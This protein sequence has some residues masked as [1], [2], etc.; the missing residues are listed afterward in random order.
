MITPQSFA[1]LKGLLQKVLFPIIV[2]LVASTAPAL[3]GNPTGPTTTT[4]TSSPATAAVSGATVTFTATV[5]LTSGGTAVNAGT[6]KL[7]DGTTSTQIGSTT[8]VN[9]SG[10]ATFTSSTL[11]IQTH[12]IQAQYTD[13]AGLHNSNS[14]NLSLNITEPTALALTSS[15]ASPGFGT[16]VT[17]TATVTNGAT[18]AAITSGL[19]TMKIFDNNGGATLYNGSVPATGIVTYS[20]TTLAIGTHPITAQYSDGTSW[21]PTANTNVV[22]SV[23]S[24]TT[25]SSSANPSTFG[26]S[27]TFTATVSSSGGTPT[28]TVRFEDGV[29]QPSPSPAPP[30]IATVALS[31]GTATFTTTALAGGT[32]PITAEFVP[33]VGGLAA[34]SSPTISQVVNTAPTTTTVATPAASVVGA[35]VAL[36][37]TVTSGVGTPGGSV[38]FIDSGQTIGTAS[39]ITGAATLNTTA[40]GAGSHTIT[41]QYSGSSNFT[42]SSALTG[43][44]NIGAATT[45]TT[46]SASPASAGLGGAVNFT[47]LVSASSG[48]PSG[49]VT[50]TD[51]TTGL[52]V[53]TA[54]LSGGQ[55]V[56]STSTLASGSHTIIATYGGTS[57]YGASVS[58]TGAAVSISAATTTLA[59]SALPSPA[60]ALGNSVLTAVILPSGGPTPTGT[61][62][63]TDNGNPVSG[64]PAAVNASGQASV[65]DSGLAVGT[66]SLAASYTGSGSAAGGSSTGTASLTVGQSTSTTVVTSSAN[67]QTTPSNSIT[68]TATVTGAG[69]PTGS[70]IF[71][72]GTLTLATVPLASGVATLSRTL[73]TAAHAI[74]ATYSGDANDTASQGLLT[75]N[76][77]AG[78]SSTV[79]TVSPS[80]AAPGQTVTLGA[81]VVGSS[82]TGTVTFY[83][84]A[85]PPLTIVGSA[86]VGAQIV[87]TT[88]STG[89]HSLSAVYSGDSNNTTSTSS[90]QTFTIAKVSSTTTLTSVTANPGIAGS[91]VS[92][93]YHIASAVST[94]TSPTGIVSFLDGSSNIGTATL[95]SNNNGNATLTTSSLASGSHTVTAAYQGDNQNNASTSLALPFSVTNGGTADF[96]LGTSISYGVTMG[97]GQS[98]TIPLS[99][100]GTN[101]FS[102]T[103]TITC[104]GLPQGA[105]CVSSPPTVAV[106]SSSPTS[107]SVLLSTTG[108]HSGSVAPTGHAIR[109]A[110]IPLFGLAALFAFMRRRRW[111][112][113]TVAGVFALCILSACG[114]GGGGSTLPGVGSNAGSGS[115]LGIGTGGSSGTGGSGSATPAPGATDPATDGQPPTITA[116]TGLPGIISTSLGPNGPVLPPT[117][118]PGAIVAGALTPGTSSAPAGQTPGGTSTV[119]IVATGSNGVAHPLN[120]TVV[121][122]P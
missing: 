57:N 52:T 63:F 96:T 80:S 56:A 22:I 104:V 27:V 62:T 76:V 46:V 105:T 98:T 13:P 111:R 85:S 86:Q 88:L 67:P 17:I 118:A 20:T 33:Q 87:V 41:A 93:S 74:S 8:A 68:F 110:A 106:N 107:V 54:S 69:T 16:N 120:I 42:N 89:T 119:A 61:V 48:S 49:T 103:V 101:G 112:V 109:R 59:L 94:G 24:T 82:P 65:T 10:V 32:H 18:G 44:F 38:A 34:S 121:I 21:A 95:A 7:M 4:L 84:G 31:S 11:A 79:I 3:A 113:A 37:A 25:V 114:G 102:G 66:H 51:S 122:A 15:P 43:A 50:F 81:T 100:Q 45:T 53:G 77:G 26:S 116:G 73:N 58:P 5:T 78:T 75:E 90:L 28:G 92:F 36:A 71:K 12:S 99:L 60:T 9:G 39:L 40:L 108:A 72:D 47:A 14:S 30:A 97:A 70:V 91:P 2:A 6:V 55:A 29:V 23:G 117:V 64:S 115:G 83:D 19:G 35:T 1:R